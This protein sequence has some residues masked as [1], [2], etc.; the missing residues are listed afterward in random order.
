MKS[1]LLVGVILCYVFGGLFLIYCHV[2]V[3]GRE[4]SLTWSLTSIIGFLCMGTKFVLGLYGVDKGVPFQGP[5]LRDHVTTLRNMLV[6]V[7]TYLS[8]S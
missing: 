1:L 5:I 8:W 4:S 3:A 6:V 7:S 2:D